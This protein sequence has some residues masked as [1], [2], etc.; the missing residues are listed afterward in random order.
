MG[1]PHMHD[2]HCGKCTLPIELKEYKEILLM[3][4]YVGSRM[5]EIFCSLNIYCIF[6]LTDEG[7]RSP[8]FF[9]KS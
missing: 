8:I 6:F 4:K 1:I 9:F 2:S 3:H 7:A 5:L